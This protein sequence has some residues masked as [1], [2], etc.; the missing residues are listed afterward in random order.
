MSE[1]DTFDPSWKRRHRVKDACNRD[2]KTVGE[3]RFN[4]KLERTF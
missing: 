2:Q 4:G 1:V 3:F